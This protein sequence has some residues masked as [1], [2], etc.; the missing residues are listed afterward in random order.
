MDTK[1]VPN[2]KSIKGVKL[3]FTEVAEGI[4]ISGYDTFVMKDI[5][6]VAG[7]KWNATAKTW[8]IPSGGYDSVRQAA[9]ELGAK[10]TEEKK[11][12]KLFDASP[13]GQAILQ[14]K[15]KDL[16]VEAFASGKYHWIC[17]EQCNVIDWGRGHTSCKVHAE[18]DGQS[19]NCFRVKGR[20]YTGT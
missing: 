19:W 4:A 1:E 7:G 17:C 16:V 3:V 18:F 14:Q 2:M 11:A 10:R 15:A 13:E 8:T 5:I 20:L 6:K 9:V 12:K